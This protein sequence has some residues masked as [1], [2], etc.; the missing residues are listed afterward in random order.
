MTLVETVPPP[1]RLPRMSMLVATLYRV[2]GCDGFK[3]AVLPPAKKEFRENAAPL[4]SLMVSME[5]TFAFSR[6]AEVL[7]CR[8][9][10]LQT[11]RKELPAGLRVKVKPWLSSDGAL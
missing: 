11:Y 3:S 4:L 5:R 6:A 8:T 10:G 7:L 2:T 1:T 9:P